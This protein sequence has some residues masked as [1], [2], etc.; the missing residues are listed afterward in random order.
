MTHGDVL[1]SMTRERVDVLVHT[2]AG[3]KAEIRTVYREAYGREISEER[4]IELLEPALE[5]AIPIMISQRIEEIWGAPVLGAV[6]VD[7][8]EED[9]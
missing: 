2:L 8:E 9:D 1:K 6:P 4:L 7:A 3:L 5:A